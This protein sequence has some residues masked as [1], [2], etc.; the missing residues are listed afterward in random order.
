MILTDVFKLSIMKQNLI[1]EAEMKWIQADLD[2]QQSFL[3]I[4]K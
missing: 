4:L 2:P 3:H 1:Q